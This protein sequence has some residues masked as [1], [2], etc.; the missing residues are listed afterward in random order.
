M[1]LDS[2]A[3]PELVRLLDSYGAKLN[4]I[5]ESGDTALI[6]AAASVP[7][8]VIKSLIDAGADVNVANKQGQTALMNAADQN[9][10]DSVRALLLAGAKVNVRNK[11]GES[12]WDLATDDEV[13]DL[14]VSFG[15]EVKE[16]AVTEG[17]FGVE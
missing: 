15:A 7:S 3:T 4:L 13:E 8:E 1:Q 2:Y 17:D 9:D 6:R 5:N 12:A 16:S 11:E 14:L 10:L